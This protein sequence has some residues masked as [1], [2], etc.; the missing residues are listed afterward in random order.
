MISVELDKRQWRD[1][2][3]TL[4]HI[5]RGL[6]KAVSRAVNKTA[7]TARSRIVKGIF[8]EIRM[9]QTDIRKALSLRKATY[10]V[11]EAMI[12][13]GGKRIPLIKFSARQVRRG[14]SYGMRRSEGRQTIPGAFVATMPSGHVGVFKRRG[15]VR[16]PIKERFGPSPMAVF[17]RTPGLWSKMRTDTS[18]LLARNLDTQVRVLLEKAG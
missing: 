13:V 1:V 18:V 12:R 3:R 9:K 11:F 15:K 17:D 10:R 5:P 4:R 16:K 7:T 14:V 8:A 6:P 2:Q